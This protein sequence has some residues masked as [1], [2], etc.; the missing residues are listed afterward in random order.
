[1]L[2]A[3]TVHI[4]VCDMPYRQSFGSH[5]ENMWPVNQA[6][7]CLWM[8]VVHGWSQNFATSTPVSRSSCDTAHGNECQYGTQ[9]YVGDEEGI[10]TGKPEHYICQAI[11]Y[12]CKKE[13][14]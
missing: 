1:M 2:H 13:H 14:T 10:A 6:R 5:V 7:T 9:H 8:T 12:T 11:I 4:H 3:Y